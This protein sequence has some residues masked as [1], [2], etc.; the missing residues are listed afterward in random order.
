MK[1]APTKTWT[2]QERF[3]LELAFG[4]STVIAYPHI[5]QTQ[6]SLGRY[7]GATINEQRFCYV[8]E[9]DELIRLDAAKLIDSIRKAKRKANRLEQQDA[10]LAAQL[11]LV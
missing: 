1:P 11:G 6:L 2:T 4:P 5:S 8:P 10:A 3:E 7:R 9:S